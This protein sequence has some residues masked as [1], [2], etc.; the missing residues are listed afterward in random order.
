MGL[1]AGYSILMHHLRVLTNWPSYYTPLLIV[2]ALL[3]SA[4]AAST[5]PFHSTDVYGYI[6]EAGS[7]AYQ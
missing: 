5:T 1:I 4:L 3:L 7:S 2:S 6:N